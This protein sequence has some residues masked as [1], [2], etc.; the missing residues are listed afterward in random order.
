MDLAGESQT[1]MAR[2]G[3][4]GLAARGK[5]PLSVAASV[6][7]RTASL[8]AGGLY[9]PR[10]CLCLQGFPLRKSRTEPM[11]TTQDCVCV[12]VYVEVG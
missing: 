8:T 5:R 1:L 11:K 4:K 10:K 9:S 2:I 3:A 6:T 7:T 12:C